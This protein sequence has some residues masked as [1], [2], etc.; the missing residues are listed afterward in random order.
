[1]RCT[2]R[3]KSHARYLLIGVLALF[4]A[5]LFVPASP[6]YQGLAQ[7]APQQ[8]AGKSNGKIAFAH[9]EDGSQKIY[10]MNADGSNRTKLTNGYWD[11][12]PAW[13]PDGSRIA[14]KR[15][16]NKNSPSD[17]YIMNADGT[18]QLLLTRD[19]EFQDAAAWSPDG[20]KIA[21]ASW[22]ERDKSCSSCWS[23]IH[24]INSDG[25]NEVQ[26]NRPGFYRSPTWSPDGKKIAFVGSGSIY[27]IDSDGSNQIELAKT[28]PTPQWPS[29]V[30]WSPNGSEMLIWG[31]ESAGDDSG[32]AKARATIR[33]ISALKSDRKGRLIG[34][35]VDPV[36][37][38]DGSKIA[39]RRGDRI[40]VMDSHG[41]NLIGLTEVTQNGQEVQPAW[42]P[43]ITSSAKRLKE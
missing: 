9:R 37:S 34:H 16:L 10:V 38:P 6:A 14:L 5:G 39:F 17:L 30:S 18:N 25:S 23:N 3:L 2:G 11:S 19:V 43:E 32:Y 26:L 36:W 27:V 21:F 1:M 41:K 24:I 13:S 31:Y 22:R 12:W 28:S 40:F 33:A 15:R 42:G 20:T 7:E 35:G 29:S 8:V 4:G